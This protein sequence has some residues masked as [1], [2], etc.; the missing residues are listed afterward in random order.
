MQVG[1]RILLTLAPLLMAV[2]SVHAECA[3]VLWEEHRK[4]GTSYGPR[5][6]LYEAVY[7]SRGECEEQRRAG[8]AIAGN[9]NA[10]KAA[11]RIPDDGIRRFYQCIPDT[12]DPR[13]PKG[14]R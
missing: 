9:D 4:V 5:G 11:G 1:P 7:V 13:G 10:T 8:E 14:S 6:F 12:V 3:W 2:G